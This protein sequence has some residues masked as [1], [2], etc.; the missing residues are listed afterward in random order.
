V[1]VETL[2][3]IRSGFNWALPVTSPNESYLVSLKTSEVEVSMAELNVSDVSIVDAHFERV[4]KSQLLMPVIENT[5]RTEDDV[6]GF[7]S[8]RLAFVGAD[9]H[10]EVAHA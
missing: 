6:A 8:G 7:L 5:S 2:Y 10:S 9:V 4:Q 3:K 1:A